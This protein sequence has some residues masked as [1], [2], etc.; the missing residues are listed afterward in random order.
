MHLT[1]RE[2]QILALIL[3][4]QTAN[5]QLSH[6]LGI[7]EGTVKVHLHSLYLKYQV[8]TRIALVLEVFREIENG[9]SSWIHHQQHSFVSRSYFLSKHL[10]REPQDLHTDDD[11]HRVGSDSHGNNRGLFIGEEQ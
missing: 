8:T 7:A 3:S 9:R 5:K 6:R 4:G 11:H 10:T 1:T 2:Q